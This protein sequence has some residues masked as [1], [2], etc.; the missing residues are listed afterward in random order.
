MKTRLAT[1]LIVSSLTSL[2]LAGGGSGLSVRY[3]CAENIRIQATYAGQHAQ[4]VV[5]GQVL[6]MNTGISASGARYVGAGYTWWTKGRTAELYR[7][8]T[9]GKLTSLR[10]CQEG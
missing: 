9:P 1:L 10:Q 4:V 6:E 7:G 5:N 8:E 3:I 2:A